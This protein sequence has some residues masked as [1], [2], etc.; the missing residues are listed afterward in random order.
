MAPNIGRHALRLGGGGVVFARHI[1]GRVVVALPSAIAVIA[2]LAIPKE[3]YQSYATAELNIPAVVVDDRSSLLGRC[4]SKSAL[5]V[6]S[7]RSKARST[8]CS[9]VVRAA[10]LLLYCSPTPEEPAA[11]IA[12]SLAQ[13]PSRR[14]CSGIQWTQHFERPRYPHTASAQRA[15]RRVRLRCWRRVRPGWQQL[16]RLFQCT[17]Q[18]QQQQRSLR[19]RGRSFRAGAP[20]AARTVAPCRT[21]AVRRQAREAP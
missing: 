16:P 11:V 1:Q 3:R 21:H 7:V 2:G 12:A 5:S 14:W 20:T 9:S 4:R 13:R 17:W 19:G 15:H 10:Q 8:R 6:S 18:P